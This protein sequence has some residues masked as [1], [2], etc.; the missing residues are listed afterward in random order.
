MNK[1][2]LS[3]SKYCKSVQCNKILWM[4]KYKPEVAIPTARDSV[5]KNGTEVGELAKKY[6]EI[7]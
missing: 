7:T 6:L 1:I 3:K 2:H 5:L 4:D